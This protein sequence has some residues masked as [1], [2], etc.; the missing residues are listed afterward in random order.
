MKKRA[1]ISE[2][3]EELIKGSI[4]FDELLAQEL[5]DPEFRKGWEARRP[6]R[7]LKSALVAARIKGE[8]TQ[9]EI[10]ERAGTTQSAIAR[11]ES[12]RTNP[13]LAFMQRLAEALDS[14]LEV[15]L[16]KNS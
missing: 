8:L 5:L 6:T 16:V 10:A 12:G 2:T 9:A 1:E 11:F 7:E 13:T 3:R 4:T 15:R 14:K